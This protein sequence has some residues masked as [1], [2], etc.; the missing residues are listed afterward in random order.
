MWEPVYQVNLRVTIMGREP[1][2]LGA[3]LAVLLVTNLSSREWAGAIGAIFV[4]AVAVTLASLGLKKLKQAIPPQSMSH[5]WAW[6]IS[7][8]VYIVGREEI[9]K[10]LVL[11]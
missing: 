1:W 9:C 4:T 7:K 2:E 11:R 8:D 3:L 10:P 5:A 6:L